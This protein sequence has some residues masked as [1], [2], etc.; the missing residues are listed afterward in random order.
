MKIKPFFLAPALT[1]LLGAASCGNSS[2]G[3]EA[4]IT[5]EEI[6][7]PEF[8]AD[9]AYSY[10]QKQADF[11]SRVPNSKAHEACG[12]YLAAKL[13]SFGAKVYNQYADLV[14]YDGTTLKARNIIGA[15]KPENKK[16]VM[17]CAHWDSRPYA[18]YDDDPSR[19]KTPILGIN[20]GASG[21]G[22]LLEVAR[23]LQQQ[24]PTLGIDIIFFDAEDYG[25]PE[26]YKGPYKA[27]TWCLGSQ[28]WGRTPHVAGY[29]ARFGIL[30]DMVGAK[31]STFYYEGYSARTANSP[32]KRIWERAEALG[33]NNYFIAQQGGEVIDDHVY[34]NK[35]TGIPCVDIINYE[36]NN[37]HSSFGSTWHTVQD[38]MEVIDKAT[39]QA[40]GETITAVIYNE[41]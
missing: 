1:L 37:P 24:E 33:Y 13:E 5:M 36:P 26:F 4:A 27:D 14:A 38:N 41:K 34:V 40:V 8:Q 6:A 23:L 9:S 11:G 20:D 3:K 12:D 15:Y 19:H 21:V 2:K 10:I 31:E 30:L 39:L 35:L 29:N 7:L 17:L 16:R 32:M 25:I 22:V 18:D 28:Y